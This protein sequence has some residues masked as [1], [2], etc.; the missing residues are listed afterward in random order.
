MDFVLTV[1]GLSVDEEYYI[2]DSSSSRHLAN[3]DK[4]LEDPKEYV[5]ECV[6]ANGGYLRINKRGSVT[7]TTTIMEKTSKVRL[8]DVQYAE[9]L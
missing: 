4:L 2:P 3:D 6:A 8:V 5:C 9:S 7:I 1:D